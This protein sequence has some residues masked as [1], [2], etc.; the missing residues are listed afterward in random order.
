MLGT[1]LESNALCAAR[2]LST[3]SPSISGAKYPLLIQHCRHALVKV[4]TWDKTVV[5]ER[6]VQR[7]LQSG[8]DHRP[9]AA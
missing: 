6:Y 9:P 5:P 4:R 3:F 2:P 1:S 7:Q 8:A